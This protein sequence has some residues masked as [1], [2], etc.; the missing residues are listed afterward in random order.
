MHLPAGAAAD[1][2]ADSDRNTDDRHWRLLHRRLLSDS[3]KSSPGPRTSR[4]NWRKH[5]AGLRPHRPLREQ[6][7]FLLHVLLPRCPIFRS[8]RPHLSFDSDD[9]VNQTRATFLRLRDARGQFNIS[10]F[11]SPR[12][13][14]KISRLLDLYEHPAFVAAPTRSGAHLFAFSLP[15]NPRS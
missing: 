7:Q 12:S 15:V 11:C 4:A 8:D 13:A 2:R 5:S 9:T 10:C 14:S 6:S 3:R 1:L